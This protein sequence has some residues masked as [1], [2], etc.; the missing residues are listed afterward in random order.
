MVFDSTVIQCLSDIDRF[1]ICMLVLL[2]LVLLQ[3]RLA[4]Y[5]V[6]TRIA[7]KVF[8][9]AI[10]S[11]SVLFTVWTPDFWGIIGASLIFAELLK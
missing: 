4:S 3:A 6:T 9:L 2:F 5:A 7:G 8:S 1:H 11:P 10:Y